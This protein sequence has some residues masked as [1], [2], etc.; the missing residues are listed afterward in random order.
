MARKEGEV[1]DVV[2]EEF[3]EDADKAAYIVGHNI[4]FDLAIMQTA[5]KNASMKFPLKN[6]RNFG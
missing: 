6:G 4:S 2:L 5:Y 1:L 3:T